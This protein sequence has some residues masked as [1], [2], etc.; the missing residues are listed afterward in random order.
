MGYRTN[1]EDLG[2]ELEYPGHEE[3]CKIKKMM[4]CLC[5]NRRGEL[6]EYRFVYN[7]LI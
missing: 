2:G 5:L 3:Q 6:C 1:Q 4:Q 7:S